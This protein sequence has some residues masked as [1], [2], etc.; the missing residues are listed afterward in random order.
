MIRIP[1][2]F[3]GPF[4]LALG[5]CAAGWVGG[6]SSAWRGGWRR[7]LILWII[8]AAI[9]FETLVIPIPIAGPQ[10]SHP[11]LERLP[12]IYAEYTGNPEPPTLIVN[13]PLLP[14]KR[15][16]LYQQTIHELP[17]LDGALSYEPPDATEYLARF[18]WNPE[19][20]REVGVDIV[21]YQSWAAKSSLGETFHVPPDATGNAAQWADQN[22]EPLVFFRDVMQYGIAYEDD[23]LIVFVP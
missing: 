8:P 6:L 23:E 7:T 9:I 17:T 10:Y 11:A 3:I 1:A 20:L 2:R 21:L 14:K 16:F 19:Y 22:V 4:T 18:N 12:E 13:F 15:Q 5:V